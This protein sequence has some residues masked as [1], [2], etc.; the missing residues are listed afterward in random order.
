MVKNDEIW[1]STLPVYGG[2]KKNLQQE[3]DWMVFIKE[4]GLDKPQVHHIYKKVKH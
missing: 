2:D 4:K 3:L 1:N